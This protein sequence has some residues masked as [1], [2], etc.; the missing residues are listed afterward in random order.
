MMKRPASLKS[1]L[2]W[3]LLPGLLMI[4]GGTLWFS[5]Q[6]L[7]DQVDLAYDRALAGALRAIDHNIS[8]ASGGL[9]VEQPFLLLE[10]FELT[11]NARVYFR[12]A[13][14]SGLAEIGSPSLPLPDAPLATGQPQFYF[15]THEETPVRVAALARF[16]NPPLPGDPQQRVIVQVAESLGEREV[17]LAQVLRRSVE[18]DL[19]GI[20]MSVVLLVAGIVMTLRPLNRLREELE[21]RHADDL[22]PID[23]AGLPTEVRPL[24]AAVN[25]HM[26]RYAAM[27]RTQRQFLDDA[28]HQL[29]TPLTVLR[30]QVDF[31]LREAEPALVREA[32]LAM[33]EGLDRAVRMTNQMLSLA[34]VRDASLVEGGP[35]RELL[36]L[37]ALAQAV[38]RT[39]L[40]AARARRL[41]FGVETPDEPVSILG[42]EWLLREALLNLVDNAIRYTPVGG[43]VTVR[44]FHD[45]RHALLQVEDSGPGMSE[46]DIERAGVR[47]RRGAAGK[48]QPG[49]GLGLALVSTIAQLHDTA[50]RIE[51][52]EPGPGLH[53]NLVFTLGLPANAA[54]QHK[55]TAN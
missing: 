23:D 33:H 22:R 1:A 19:S 13:T 20:A 21:A 34:R 7:R 29:R 26:S 9:S 40:P 54:V 31:A 5:K 24:V 14:E 11:T 37:N 47:F 50:L 35:P 42:V 30:T 3:W 2:L 48:L 28:S 46:H 6:L 38:S 52:R 41:D 55:K 12:V 27:A 45:T 15:A 44:V 32:L 53:M 17:F 25:R 36:D 18:R 10:F 43:R 4:M 49:A 16:M 8:T 39:L 51:P